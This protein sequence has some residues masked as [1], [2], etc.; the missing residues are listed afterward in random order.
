MQWL[1]PSDAWN[2]AFAIVIFVGLIVVCW[3]AG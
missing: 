2:Y 3:I 1:Q